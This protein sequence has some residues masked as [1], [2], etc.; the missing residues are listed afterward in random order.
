MEYMCKYNKYSD[1][2]DRTPGKR[3]G[4]NEPEDPIPR[5]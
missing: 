1:A 4:L 5:Q 3:L 2:M